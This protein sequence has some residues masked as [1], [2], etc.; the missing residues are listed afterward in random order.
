VQEP[1]AEGLWLLRVSGRG[2]PGKDHQPA[3]DI[4]QQG[5]RVDWR[6]CL[7]Q[8]GR[9]SGIAGRKRSRQ[10]NPH[11]HPHWSAGQDA[12]RSSHFGHQ[13]GERHCQHPQDHRS[14]PAVRHPL[15]RTH[16]RRARRALPSAQA[17]L[18]FQVEDP[19]FTGE[20][21]AGEE[22]RRQSDDLFRWNAQAALA[23]A[24]SGW[25]P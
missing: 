8:E 21:G 25:R 22:H 4:Q 24:Q 1:Q 6:H 17:A 15:G 10:V 9:D 14:L 5:L 18:G 12:R 16:C 2:L 13:R 23:G 11:Q 20:R 7:P 3:E 19:C